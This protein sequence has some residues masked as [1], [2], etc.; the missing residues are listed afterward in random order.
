MM[1]L[2]FYGWSP[3]PW[4]SRPSRC[5]KP[6]ALITRYGIVTFKRLSPAP[7]PNSRTTERTGTRRSVASRGSTHFP[8][9]GDVGFEPDFCRRVP[10][11]RT[12]YIHLRLELVSNT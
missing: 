6:V 2:P 12:Q 5:A 1:R 8:L 3:R 7:Q 11:Q 9:H 4:P 10:G